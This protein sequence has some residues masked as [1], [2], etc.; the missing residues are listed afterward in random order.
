MIYPTAKSPKPHGAPR[1]A[2]MKSPESVNAVVKS[3][4]DIMRRFERATTFGI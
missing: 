1:K 3:I 2:K 4:C